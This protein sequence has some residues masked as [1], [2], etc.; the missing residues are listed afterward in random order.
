MSH[1]RIAD[2]IAASKRPI[3]EV[4]LEEIS[5]IVLQVLQQAGSAPRQDVA[6]SVCR[7][8]GMS[9]ATAPA[10]ARVVLAIRGLRDMLKIIETDGNI[11]LPS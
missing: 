10:V 3:D 9:T 11:R 7:L 8:V 2:G 4:C 6:R 1:F 5:A